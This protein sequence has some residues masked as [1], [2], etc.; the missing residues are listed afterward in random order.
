M[1]EI[2]K[3]LSKEVKKAIEKHHPKTVLLQ[4]P[5]GLRKYALDIADEIDA[6]VFI[7]GGSNFG[8]CDIPDFDVD[9]II[10][11]GHN[12]LKRLPPL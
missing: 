1:D 12:E 6:E 8:A 3:K 2:Y 11:F 5:A 7:W 4:F 10:H 9:L